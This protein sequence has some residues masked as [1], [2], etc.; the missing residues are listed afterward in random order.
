MEAL[1]INADRQGER[2]KSVT[3][4]LPLRLHLPN[5]D[6]SEPKTHTLL[7]EDIHVWF[8]G[9]PEAI[10]KMSAP[11][12]GEPVHVDASALVHRQRQGVKPCADSS[13]SGGICSRLQVF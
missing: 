8:L 13:K 4:H 9:I 6:Q 7:V 5:G 1:A 10:R 3:E 11:G 12:R 2:S